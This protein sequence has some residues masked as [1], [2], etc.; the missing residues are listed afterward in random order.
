MQLFVG[1]V[2][3]LLNMFS[4][5]IISSLP[6]SKCLFYF[7]A[8][9][10]LEPKKEKSVTASTFLPSVCDELMRPHAKILVFF[11]VELQASFFTLFF[12][13]LQEAL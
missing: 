5:F 6:R 7:M 9:V 3:S 8:P 11:N 4:R 13:A 12:H 1:K 2:M 10:I